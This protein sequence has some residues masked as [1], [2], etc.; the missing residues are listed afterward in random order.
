MRA[1]QTLVFDLNGTLTD[2]AALGAPWQLPDL[3]DAVL[4]GAIGTAM[5]E[6]LFG[7]HHEFSQHVESAL[8]LEAGRRRLD[9]TRIEAALRHAQRL[10]PFDDVTPALERLRASGTARLAVLT[11]SGAASGR[12]TLETAGLD[13][14]FDAILGVDAVRVFKPH[15]DTYAHALAEL[16]HVEPGTVFMVA[17]HPWDLAGA[18][19]AGM[20]TVLVRRRGEP[21][22]AVFPRPDL[23]VSDLAELAERL[24]PEAH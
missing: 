18:K 4:T 10:P 12:R 23:I 3:G 13:G 21:L 1:E 17:A 24:E 20:R 7:A 14:Y 22:P 19:H 15:P 8:R 5:A 9:P 6:T 11:N 2:P 16:G